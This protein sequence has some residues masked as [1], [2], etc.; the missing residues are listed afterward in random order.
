MWKSRN[1]QTNQAAA[2]EGEGTPPRAAFCGKFFSQGGNFFPMGS[3][4][5][6]GFPKGKYISRLISES[7]EFA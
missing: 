4:K 3:V 7:K 1:N 2:P 5:D 6:C